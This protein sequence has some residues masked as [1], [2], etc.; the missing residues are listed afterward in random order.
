MKSQDDTGH[1]DLPYVLRKG[2]SGH[3]VAELQQRLNSNG[4]HL[5][6]DGTFNGSTHTALISFQQKQGLLGYGQVD[7]DTWEAL[8]RESKPEEDHRPS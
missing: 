5:A 3:A 7:Q 4:S 6:V 2:D 8:H 1:Q